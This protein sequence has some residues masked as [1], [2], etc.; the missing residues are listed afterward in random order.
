MSDNPMLASLYEKRQKA[1]D[2]VDQTLSQAQAENRNLVDAEINNLNGYREQ[3]A[4]LDAQIKPIEEFEKVRDE[5][6]SF[7]PA[8]PARN[9][10]DDN[11]AGEQRG[12]R[13]GIQP[14]E[15]KYETAGHFIVDYIRAKGYPGPGIQPADDAR[16]RVNAAMGRDVFVMQ[17]A[18]GDV[19]P[20]VHQTTDDTPG[21]L[22]KPIVGQVLTDI[23]GTRPF[24]QSIGGAK[25]MS[26]IPGK[27]FS[28][29]KVTQHTDVGEQAQE[30]AELVSRELKIDGVDFTK[31]T[32]GGWLNVSRQEIDWTSPNAWNIIVNDLESVYGEETEDTV[33]AWFAGT[34][35]QSVNVAGADAEDVDSWV[36]ALYE[37]AV[38]SATAN[39]TTRARARRLSNH[40]WCSIDMWA[41][42]GSLL[43]I[44]AAR[45]SRTNAGQAS[46]FNF[47]GDMLG[48][49]RTLVPGVPAGTLVVGREDRVEFY[50]ERI[51]LLQA[52]EPRVLGVEIAYGGYAAYGNLDPTAF[53]KIAVTA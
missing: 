25:D 38:K 47:N 19:A 2:F 29:P 18:A 30:K 33:G 45:D 53:T 14:R 7:A 13:L 51:G 31:K 52:I 50:E 22:P 20:G 39:G 27:V 21:L 32:Y 35:S 23:D 9:S 16:Q 6:R 40:I 36:K 43:S 28:R 1:I 49:A 24:I 17:R 46:P 8:A 4:A 41:Q 15:V 42:V 3:I 44:L 10:G 5:H 12:Q 37:A 48:T 34:V 26:G 11:S